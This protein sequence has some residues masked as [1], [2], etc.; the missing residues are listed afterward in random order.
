MTQDIKNVAA[1]IRTR[2]LQLAKK[3]REDFNFLLSRYASDRIL[4][5]L[6]Q[7]EYR[8]SF[9]L[10]GATLFTLWNGEPH[11]ATKDIDLLGFGTHEVEALIEIFIKVC[12]Q[13]CQADGIVFHAVEGEKIKE[14]QEYE[15]V[16]LKVKGNLGSAKITIQ[17]DIGFGDVVTPPPVEVDMPQ[18][19]DLPTTRLQ[20]YHQETAIAEKFQAIVS[21]GIANSRVKDFYD[22]WFLSQNFDFQGHLLTEAIQA[23]FKR[24]QTNVPLISPFALT[25]E[26]A[27]D[28]KTQKLWQGFIK[29]NKLLL[30]PP[31]F[32]EVI[33]SIRQFLMPVCLEITKDEDNKQMWHS[34]IQR[35][36]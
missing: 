33:A 31:S 16:R 4:Y 23:T 35:W 19:L 9:V 28:E 21:L 24:R 17:V 7:S 2:L 13:P 18:I 20:I 32:Q 6:S 29:K 25:E 34:S 10:K 3:N 5:R 27:K 30:N 12:Q 14:E 15:G 11:R 1:S 8:H 26:F 36:L 22:I